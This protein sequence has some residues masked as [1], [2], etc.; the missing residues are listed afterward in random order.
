MP[1][2]R[3]IVP[4]ASRPG[5]R[6]NSG[7]RM[8][9][10]HSVPLRWNSGALRESHSPPLSLVKMT[11]VF[12]GELQSIQRVENAADALIGALEHRNVVRARSGFA[13]VIP[14][15]FPFRKIRT[16]IRPVRRV[17]GDLEKER[18]TGALLDE[19]FAPGS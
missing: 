14:A 15:P 10:S 2:C 1:T 8:P 12:C 11:S 4:A 9:P 13:I 6:S 18:S 3:E 7:T 19:R 5:Q 17:V 16:L